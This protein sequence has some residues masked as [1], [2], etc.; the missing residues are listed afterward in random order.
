[1]SRSPDVV[2]AWLNVHGGVFHKLVHLHAQLGKAGIDCEL[3]FASGPPRG[4]KVGVDVPKALIP[5][6][7]SSGVHFLPRT[8]VLS[9]VEALSPRLLVCDA[10]HDQDLPGLISRA[11]ARGV[12]TA[13]M[14]TLLGDFTCH[15]ADHLLLQHPLTLFFEREYSRTPESL[16]F[17]QAKG[18]H[19]TGN[20]FFE[21][22][23]NTLFGGF[24]GRED[25]CSKYGFDPSRPI[26]LWLPSY[27]DARHEDYGL[28]VRAVAEAGCNL[29]VKL[30]PW[31]YTFLKHG[32]DTW[33]LGTTSDRI[34]GA[35]AVAEPD[36]TWAFKYCD[37]AVMRTST[38]CLE[39]PFWDRPSLLIPS[40]AYAS[41]VLA[42][43]N[44]VAS[45]ALRLHSVQDFA[46]RLQSGDIPR[47]TLDD[48][49]KARAMIRLD[50][51][52][53]AFAQTVEAVRLILESPDSAGISPAQIVLGRLYDS[54]VN[55]DLSRSLPLTR[56]IRFEIGR[57]LRRL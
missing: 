56:R 45:C 17:Q 3:L 6:L 44:M 11:R 39:I 24:A 26:C 55:D 1:M 49:A 47:F 25:F 15:G 57:L 23:V 34:W 54:Y 4:L 32:T 42:Q 53:D 40:S 36:S 10:H 31:E 5:E 20:I 18:L 14:A 21:P 22:L 13:Q 37:V 8:E 33:S 52:A 28:I 51:S 48:Y 30:H 12:V 38:T 9:R 2:F 43:A 16:R 35:S 50:T 7:A 41:L 29:A 19:F 27:E 46:A